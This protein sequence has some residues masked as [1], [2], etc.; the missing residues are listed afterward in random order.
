ME[1]INKIESA[2]ENVEIDDKGSLYIWDEII[3]SEFEN[4]PDLNIILEK[5]NAIVDLVN[6]DDKLMDIEVSDLLKMV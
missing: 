1:L 3:K 5:V 2:L 6:T 4:D